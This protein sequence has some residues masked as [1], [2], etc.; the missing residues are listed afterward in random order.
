M[1]LFIEWSKRHPQ[2]AAELREIMTTTH[3]TTARDGATEAYAQQQVRM[4]VAK[5][6]GLVWRNNV[7]AMQVRQEHTCPRCSFNF[8]VNNRPVRWGLCND[9]EKLN[10][11][12]KSSDLI[13]VMPRLITHAMVGQTIGQFVSIEVKRPGWKFSGDEHEQAQA[14]WLNLCASKGAFATFSTGAVK[15]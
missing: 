14:A 7:G 8:A 11:K 10:K 5:Q 6:G 4:Q 13:G 2:A 3:D 9:S 15:L 12:F 1:D